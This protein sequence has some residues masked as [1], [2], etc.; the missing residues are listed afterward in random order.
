MRPHPLVCGVGVLLS[1]VAAAAQE[2]TVL[3]YFNTS[4][5]EIER[6]IPEVAEAGYSA[7]WLPPPCKGA[8]G[9]FS[10]GYD[11][12]DRFDLGDKNQMGGEPTRYG[13]K[14]ELLRLIET[15]HRFG[16]RVLFDNVM[17]HTGGPL[18]NVP[19]G[20][21]FPSQHGF[22]PEDFHLVRRSSG[23]WRKASD[24]INYNDE[25]QVLN[26]NPFAWDIAQEDPNTSFDPIAQQEG[27]DY[28][29][30]RGVRMPGE[31]WF[32][33]DTDLTAAADGDAVAQ[34]PFADKEPFEDVGWGAAQSGKNTGRF[35]WNDQFFA[36]GDPRRNNGKHDAGESSEPFNDVGVS[37]GNPA[38]QT[39]AWGFGDGRRNMGDPVSEDVNGMIIRSVRWLIDQTACDGFRL[40][41]VKHVPAYF[42]G[43]QNGTGK[44]R[45][46]SGFIGGLQAQF[47]VTRGFSDWSNH[48]NTVFSTHTARDD[49]MIFGEH[50]GAP[51]NPGD[52]IN[53]GMRIA[54]DDFL[55]R[56]GG[57]N[58][59]GGSL[60]GYDQP[61]AFSFGVGTGVIYCL[62][63]DNN[64]MPGSERPAA[65]AYMLT[66]SGLPIVYTDGYNIASG[67]D[68][69]PKPAHIPFL[70]QYEQNYIT[71]TLPVR[72]DFIRGEQVPK[73]SDQDFA[74]WEFR[75]KSEN[76]NMSDADAVTLLVMHARNYTIGQ[77]MRGG[78]TFPAAAR[79]RNLSPHNGSFYVTVGNDGRLRG[80]DG[81]VVSV[82]SGKFF[83]FSWDPP[84]KTE[85][86]QGDASVRSIDIL[87]DHDQSA[88]TPPVPFP[89]MLHQRKDGKD[90][91]PDFAHAVEIPRVTTPLGVTFVARADGSAEN[92]LLKLDGGIDI[93][94]QH[95]L[96]SINAADKRDNK[97]GAARDI[98]L[99]YEQMQFARRVTEKFA[100]KNISRNVIGSPGAETWQCVIGQS[101]FTRND[102]A[103]IDADTSTA[104]WV[105]HDP[106][107]TT[108]APG[109][110]LQFS[111]PPQNA[112]GQP[113]TV[114]IKIGYQ[115]QGVTDAWFYYTSDGST[116][117]EGSA[118]TGTTG[119]SVVPLT[120]IQNGIPDGTGTPEWWR[121]TMPALPVD[122]VIRYKIGVHRL[123][124][125]A[126][127]PSDADQ[128]AKKRRMETVFQLGGLNEP[129]KALALDTLVVWPDNDFG[130][131][132]SGLDEG[133]H[134]LRT[135]A[136]LNRTGMA[137]IYR[138]ATQ[139]FY[140]DTQRPAGLIAFPSRDNQTIGGST[141]G[142]VIRTDASVTQVQFNILDSDAANDSAV[143][144]NGSGHW[145]GGREVILAQDGGGFAKEWRFDYK[146]IPSSGAASLNVRLREAS[147][148]PDNALTD[149]AGWFTTLTRTVS[150][151][152]PVNFRIAFPP[153]DGAL[154]D[155]SYVGK[156]YFDK[157]LGFSNGEP[158]PD[159]TMIGEF[160]IHL[161]GAL[162]PRSNYTIIRNETAAESA[163]AFEFPSLYNGNPDD[164]HEV[165]VAHTRGDI[166]LTD[167]RLVKAAP[168]SLP[169]A[170]GD[171]L[172][173]AWENARGLDANDPDGDFGA[174]GDPDDDGLTNLQEF[175]AGLSPITPDA[176]GYPSP[177]ITAAL[178]GYTITIPVLAGRRYQLL[179]SEDLNSWVTVGSATTINQSAPELAFDVPAFE[180]A[181]RFFRIRFS[182]P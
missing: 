134:V 157:S 159:A 102:G 156:V 52:Y 3:Q 69:F 149:A 65:H 133:F 23:G 174:T 99:G 105:F 27:N 8:S 53:A 146:D 55:N 139:T 9:G 89:R 181:R 135:R 123:D 147:S 162:Y 141:Y 36:T 158:V 41:A 4:W 98:F 96:G 171:G 86:F 62:S 59:I 145:A 54:N 179:A 175:L 106:E 68:Y 11:V 122:A 57:F 119:T 161:D 31:T 77:Q 35:D 49:A 100:A 160:A 180:T 39:A 165:R 182:L 111:P 60:G 167:S 28:P 51:P 42:F 72:R 112:A 17:A 66:R 46:S 48:R 20:T 61:G 151:G 85:V 163:L 142:V 26:R 152:V 154:V 1:F 88:A 170:D 108:Q 97:P 115:A 143:N 67:P 21:L 40:D 78:T 140:Y 173:D 153:A 117:P 109:G 164:L 166:S 95:G 34:H 29:K 50:L 172:P 178:Q 127:F 38:R 13:T 120:K 56:V 94:S 73:W 2:E 82:P 121:G 150:T 75:D 6:R 125:P 103:G 92:I 81:N 110:A 22:V 116:F 18:D 16:V 124:A 114:W 64:S 10:V 104:D 148:D 101:G 47:N 14:A 144:G 93:N 84:E 37:G 70:G 128:I 5:R 132:R 87:Y 107:S 33:P 24:A 90:G 177:Q 118:G 131:R 30:W 71:G 113:V 79:L 12:F 45:S 58:G 83:A 7:L 74:M 25:W 126:R 176:S 76:P 136:F 19:A 168:A 44:D 169:D 130:R 137:S 15:A 32:Y 91:D 63:H 129:A 80:N 138:T 43:Q 155:A